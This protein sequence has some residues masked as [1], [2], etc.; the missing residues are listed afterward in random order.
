MVPKVQMERLLTGVL[1]NK[2]VDPAFKMIGYEVQV[3]I[4]HYLGMPKSIE[5]GYVLRAFVT[6]ELEDSPYEPW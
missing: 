6:A 2:L 5:L 3:Q 4:N 1:G